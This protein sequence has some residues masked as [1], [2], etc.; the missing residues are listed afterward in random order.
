MSDRHN[1]WLNLTPEEDW[2]KR[3][4]PDLWFGRAV[5][6]F[7]WKL[8]WFLERPKHRRKMFRLLRERKITAAEINQWEASGGRWRAHILAVGPD[9]FPGWT[10]IFAR[11]I[12]RIRSHWRGIPCP[13]HPGHFDREMDLGAPMYRGFIPRTCSGCWKEFVRKHVGE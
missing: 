6:G 4:V 5:K 11:L 9:T 8:Y 3:Q 1:G 7:W 12:W 13:L 10:N 2:E